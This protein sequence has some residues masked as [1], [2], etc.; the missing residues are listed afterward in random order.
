MSRRPN[1]APRAEARS[2][3]AS[4]AGRSG[5]TTRDPY[6]LMPTGGGVAALL[7]AVG[8]V[9][10]ALLTLGLF[11]GRLPFL[12]SVGGG[13]PSGGGDVGPERTPTPSN[14]VVVPDDPRAR[15]P[16]SI[17][18]VKSGNIWVQRGAEATQITGTG[19]DSMP[20][21]APDGEWIY[22]V[23]TRT[24]RGLFPSSG[25]AVYY[26]L[27]YPILSRVRPD[28]SGREALLDG[29]YTTPNGRYEWFYWL[30]QP[31]V[32]P[33]GATLALVSDAPDPTKSDVVLQLYD[34]ATGTLTKPNVSESPPLGHQDPAWKPVGK[35]Q[36]LFVRNARD[37]TRGAPAIWKFDP[38]TGKASA[39]T[40]PGYLAPAWSPDGRYVAATKT[41][42]L[43]TNVVILDPK[44]GAELLRV[45]TDG[46]SWSPVWSPAGDAVAYFHMSGGVVDLR[47]VRLAGTAPTWT[48]DEPLDLTEAS[49]LDGGS[50]P[51]WFVPADELPEATPAPSDAASPVAS[52]AAAS[53]GAP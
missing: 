51:G 5:P 8:L 49:G 33:D 34:V 4:R 17:V 28:G 42:S 31:A 12:P 13:G 14:V 48:M 6:G 20:A 39:M 16:G 18:Y 52:G 19:Q 11:T 35:A 44:N 1:P 24:K 30:R 23:E 7:S 47:L 10:V 29:T 26:D 22:F 32:A 53:P 3:G 37:G 2:L 50:R 27:T 46:A 25:R 40:G 36:L 15:I 43:G 9:V 21:W 38:Q 41:T 45:T